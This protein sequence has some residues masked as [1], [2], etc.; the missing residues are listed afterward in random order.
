MDSLYDGQPHVVERSCE[1]EVAT[2][3]LRD[4]GSW[5]LSEERRG[6]VLFSGV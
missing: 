6:H 5:T 3:Q 1:T 2:A 4:A